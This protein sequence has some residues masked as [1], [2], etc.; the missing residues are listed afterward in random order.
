[1]A[2]NLSQDPLVSIIVPVF[3]LWDYTLRCLLAIRNHTSHI[4]HEVIVVDDASTD[5]T[6]IALPMMEGLRVIRNE[7]NEGFAKNNNKAAAVAR[8][9]YIV[10]LNNDTEVQPRWLDEMLKVIESQENVGM[11]GCKLLFPDGTVQHAGVEFSYAALEPIAPFHV[12]YKAQPSKNTTCRDLNAVTAACALMPRDLFASLGGFDEAFLMGFEDVDLCLRVRE[13]GRRIVYTPLSV[14]IHYESASE[15]RYIATRQNSELLNGKWFG[16]F[17]A[18]ENDFR[19]VFPSCQTPSASSGQRTGMSIVVVVHDHLRPGP[20]CLE[21]VLATMGINDQLIVVDDASLGVVPKYLRMFCEANA[22]RCRLVTLSEYHGLAKAWLVGLANADRPYVALVLCPWRVVQGWIERFIGH[23]EAQPV[24]G[25]ICAS[26]APG[27]CEVTLRLVNPV[28]ANA[29]GLCLPPAAKAGDVLPTDFI[30]SGAFAAKKERLIELVSRCPEGMPGQD[31]YR[32][33]TYLRQKGVVLAQ[34]TDVEAYRLNQMFPSSGEH[35][36]RQYLRNLNA[37]FSLQAVD[38]PVVSIVLYAR[39]FADN[40]VRSFRS[41]TSHT[42]R[43]MDLVVIDDGSEQSLV[44]CFEAEVQSVAGKYVV[45]ARIVRND[46]PLGFAASV[47]VALSMASGSTIVVMN[48]DVVVTAGWLQYM[49]SLLTLNA[50]I[51][52]VGPASNA[53]VAPQR[54]SQA[55]FANPPE[56]VE[57]FAEHRRTDNFSAFGGTPRLAGFCFAMKRSVIDAIGGFDV[58]L[59][60]GGG[61]MDDFCFRAARRGF[62][63]AVA[64]EAYVEHLG[65]SSE[66]TLKLNPLR[67]APKGWLAFCRKW[68]H[69]THVMDAPSLLQLFSSASGFDPKADYIPL[70]PSSPNVTQS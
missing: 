13:A 14:V 11:V 17:T 5:E 1:M 44:S 35:N 10:F 9:K 4:P 34:A 32:W 36:K 21:N 40:F 15:G 8:G 62:V 20:P 55:N 43:R 22:S 56:S 50:T 27:D 18:Y 3:N 41:L 28:P 51:G 52:I 6:S 7:R 2:T 69:P 26:E 58:R 54:S 37:A 16:R 49:S 57:R 45:S 42:S 70:I 25:V 24:I 33:A 29:G 47:N 53:G 31:P 66:H 65:T 61:E 39:N 12:E 48:A 67:P 38:Q 46:V 64:L 23:L 59:S 68:S 60:E 19:K 30:T 63:M